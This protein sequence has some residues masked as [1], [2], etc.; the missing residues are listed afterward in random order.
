MKSYLSALLLLLLVGL[1]QAQQPITA[2]QICQ[3]LAGNQIGQISE[4]AAQLQNA[5]AKIADL[6]K[7]IEDARKDKK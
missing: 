5:N 6:T 1:A 3:Q 4:L 7:Q 2:I